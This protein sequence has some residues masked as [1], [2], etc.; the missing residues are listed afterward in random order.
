MS[1]YFCCESINKSISLFYTQFVL[2]LFFF[3]KQFPSHFSVSFFSYTKIK[4]QY[5]FKLQIRK[6]RGSNYQLKYCNFWFLGK[7]YLECNLPLGQF[8]CW[9]V[10]LGAI[11]PR[12]NY[13]GNKSSERQFF[14]GAISRAILSGG[15]YLWGNYLGAIIQG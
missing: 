15:N 14:S 1:V 11:C 8:S 3:F 5:Y 13:V 10:F 6:T 4:V 12:G 2:D 9:A 7:K